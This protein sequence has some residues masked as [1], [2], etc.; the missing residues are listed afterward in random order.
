MGVIKD[1]TISGVLPEPQ[2]F[3]VH[4]PGYPSTTSRAVDTL[5][6]SQGILK[7]R[8]SQANKL[9]LRFRPEDPYCH[10]AFGERRPT[11]ALLLKIS[12]RKLPDDDGATTSNSMCGM[13]HGMQADNVESEHGAADKVDEEANLC[14]DIVGRVPEAYFFEG[15]ADYQYVVPVHADVAKRKKRNWSEPEETHLA[16][17]GRID[18]DHE[19]IMIIVPPIFAPKDMPEDLL[20]RPPTVSSSKKKEEEIVHPH[21]EID[22]EPVLALDFFQIKEIPKKVNWEEY[23]PQ[24]SEQWESQMAVSRMFDEKPIWS[25]NSLTERLL[26][27]GLSFSHGMFRRLLSRIAYYFSSGP[28]QRFWIK[29]GYDPRKDPGSRIYQRID[30]R[31]PVPLRSFCDTYSADKLKHKWG[32]ICAFR[33]FPYKFQTSLQFVELIDDYIQSE[34]NKPPMQDT[35]TFESGWFSL[36]KINCL[37]Q[38]LMVRYLSIFPKPGAESLLRVAASKFEKLKRECNREAVKLCVEERQ[39]ANTGLEES[40]E[41]ENVEDDDGEAAEA[42]NS[43]EESEEELDLTGDTEMPLPSPSHPNISMTHLQ[44]LFGSFPSDEIDGDKA[45]ENGSEEEYHI[46]EEDS[47]NYSEE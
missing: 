4:Y 12:K 23:I 25:K 29:K 35:C 37:R 31:V 14:A 5:G 13:E 11:N 43:D 28:F 7:A 3:L 22:M 40:E 32:D 42:N 20:L 39:Q 10:P 2:G 41:P 1:G 45:Q 9:E 30:Y 27:K 47:D 38:R 36:N 44:E 16:K 6:G 46:Y 24:G 8:S 26:D 15:M 21:F 17:G 19:D 34:I 33:A 18:V